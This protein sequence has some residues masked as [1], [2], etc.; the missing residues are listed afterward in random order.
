LLGVNLQPEYEKNENVVFHNQVP[1]SSISASNIMDETFMDGNTT[2]TDLASFLQR[3]VKIK[4][5][6][7]A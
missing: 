7:W 5:I 4:E 6:T 1:G 2:D 3:P